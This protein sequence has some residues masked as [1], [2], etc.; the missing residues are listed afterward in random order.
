MIEH[1]LPILESTRDISV[2]L[3]VVNVEKPLLLGLHTL[4]GSK[5]LIDSKTNHLWNHII[6]NKNP[7]RFEYMWKIKL[8]RK[9]PYL[10]LPVSTPI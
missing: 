10:Y 7:L 5:L 4:Y 1:M 2:I 3:D 6:T 9:G 8:I